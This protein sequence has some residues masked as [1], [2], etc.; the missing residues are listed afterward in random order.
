MRYHLHFKDHGGHI[1]AAESFEAE[2]D[3]RAIE[4]A[5]HRYRTGIGSGY[6]I[7]QDA[8]HIHTQLNGQPPDEGR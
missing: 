8:K 4:I 5:W 3:Q 7:W 1:F 2:S 6:E